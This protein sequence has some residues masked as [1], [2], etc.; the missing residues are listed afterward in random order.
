MRNCFK[1]IPSRDLVAQL[2]LWNKG[3]YSANLYS[4]WCRVGFEATSSDVLW[5]PHHTG[6]GKIFVWPTKCGT[7]YTN[8]CSKKSMKQSHTEQSIHSKIRVT[9]SHWNS[10]YQELQVNTSVSVTLALRMQASFTHTLDSRHTDSKDYQDDF[11]NVLLETTSL[12]ESFGCR[13]TCCAPSQIFH[14]Y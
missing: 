10:E 6:A 12:S 4:I 8:I 9:V 13:K 3:N 7:I 5:A 14:L 2:L 1:D 11:D